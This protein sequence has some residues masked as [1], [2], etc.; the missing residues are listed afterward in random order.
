MAKEFNMASSRKAPYAFPSR[1][2]SH[3][4]MV[5]QDETKKLDDTNKIVLTDEYGNYTTDVER[6]DSG[7]AD[8]NRFATSRLAKLFARSTKEKGS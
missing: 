6:L 3:A 5:N 1:F 4:I 2:G 8:P 7:I